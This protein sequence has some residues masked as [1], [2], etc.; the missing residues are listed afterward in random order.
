[1]PLVRIDAMNTDTKSLFALSEAVRDALT[2]TIGFP[3]NDLFHIVQSHDGTTGFV[4]W[5]DYLDV[6]RDA[7]IVYVQVVLRAGKPAE[8]KQAFY[9][10]AAEL[11]EQR[12]GVEPRN[13]VI[14]MTENHS[15][16]WSLGHGV[17]QYL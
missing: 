6:P 11:A 7:G 14:T 12:A 8:A 16:D 17:A 9:A 2:E 5:G 1:M 15:E 10:R 4:R 3:A 13:L